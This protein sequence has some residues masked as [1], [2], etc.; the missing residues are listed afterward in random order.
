M[1][2]KPYPED[3]PGA[4]WLRGCGKELSPLGVQ[5]AGILWDVF[6]GIYHISE[7]VLSKKVDWT[8]EHWITLSLYGGMA[9]YDGSTL[10]C[11]VIACHDRF[12]RMEMEGSK[13]GYVK[14][15]F[16][17]RSPKGDGFNRHPSLE[18][19]MK[20]WREKWGYNPEAK[21]DRITELEALLVAKDKAL[22]G[23]LDIVKAGM[24]AVLSEDFVS[25]ALHM[26]SA[27][28]PAEDKHGGE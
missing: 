13:E 26:T 10:T 17:Q 24:G 22:S 7:E 19:Q 6:G 23:I 15:T 9:T 14:V 2:R 8:N 16:H 12:V 27:T 20:K 28:A 4:K 3:N 25:E 1:E 5:V 18:E 21:D 11:F